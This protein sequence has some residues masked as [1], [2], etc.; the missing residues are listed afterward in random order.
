MAKSGVDSLIDALKASGANVDDKFSGHKGGQSSQNT[1]KT[2]NTSNTNTSNANN[3]GDQGGFSGIP[4]AILQS[5]VVD[6]AR[7][8][9]KRGKII[10]AIIVVLILAIAY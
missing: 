8:M 3:A 7:N 1:T 2:N 6:K 9:K 5:G 4:K 10:T